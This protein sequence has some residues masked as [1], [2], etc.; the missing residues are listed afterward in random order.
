MGAMQ[1]DA[2]E[3][4]LCELLDIA[5]AKF[6]ARTGPIWSDYDSGAEIA[7]FVLKCKIGIENGTFDQGQARKLWTLFAPT[8]DWDDVIGDV[9]LGNE[10]FEILDYLYGRL[11]R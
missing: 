6:A 11:A 8:C 5:S 10:I 9:E 1:M 3:H 2:R 4:H 7:A